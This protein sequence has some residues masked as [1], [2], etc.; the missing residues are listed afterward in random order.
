MSSDTFGR[1]LAIVK[2][3]RN[4]A[5]S[6]SLDKQIAESGHV[7]IASYPHITDF[8][9]KSPKNLANPPDFVITDHTSSED[10]AHIRRVFGHRNITVPIIIITDQEQQ[11][12]VVDDNL[13]FG[14]N[15]FPI[16]LQ[17]LQA[18]F[19]ISISLFQRIQKLEHELSGQKLIGQAKDILSKLFR[20][21]PKSA[22]Q[23]L[24]RM[25]TSRQISMIEQAKR[26]IAYYPEFLPQKSKRDSKRKS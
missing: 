17:Q 16:S 3:I 15:Y 9:Q 6:A 18:G 21:N 5:I 2:I 19:I 1:S 25:A 10:V 12:L 22:H 20:I 26:V 11:L 13:V 14:R 4:P 24:K 7:V 8:S 23:R